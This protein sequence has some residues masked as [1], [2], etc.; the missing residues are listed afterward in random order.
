MINSVARFFKEYISIITF[1]ILLTVFIFRSLLFNISTNLPDWN[2]YPFIIW[3]ISQNVEHFQKGTINGF[4]DTNAMYPFKGNLLFCEL[5]LPQSLMAFILNLFSKNPVLVFNIIFFITIFLN[6]FAS[7]FFWKKFNF[8]KYT[9]VFA[10]LVTAY[11][12]II[13]LNTIHFQ[14]FSIWPMFF[15]LAYL[16]SE[17][18]SKRNAILLGIWTSILFVSSAY[19]TIFMLF[20]IFFWFLFKAWKLYKLKKPFHQLLKFIL[21]TSII[22]GVLAGPFIYKFINVQKSYDIKREYWEYIIYSAQFTDYFFTAGYDSVIY[23][24]PPFQR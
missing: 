5:F 14:I 24:L 2:D 20:I 7:F 19:L 3:T 8:S 22:F 21:V 1:F 9:T 12:P 15:G 17:K 10:T 6:I 18:M 16:F 23:N 13:F 11:S 4:F